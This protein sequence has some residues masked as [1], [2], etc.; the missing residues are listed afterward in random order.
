M[1]RQERRILSVE[2]LPLAT[3]HYRLTW[4][5]LRGQEE[6]Q[7]KGKVQGQDR[8]GSREGNSKVVKVRSTSMTFLR[9]EGGTSTP[10][11]QGM[12]A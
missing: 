2:G 6:D 5:L 10:H 8:R 4:L 12:G 3:H 9:W 1:Q 7:G 11:L